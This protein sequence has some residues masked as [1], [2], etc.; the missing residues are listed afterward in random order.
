MPARLLVQ[1]QLHRPLYH[2]GE[3]VKCTV[4]LSPT[5][6]L[7]D[8]KYDDATTPYDTGVLDGRCARA[9]PAAPVEVLSATLVCF[10][11][12]R[13]DAARLQIDDDR[14]GEWEQRLRD[15]LPVAVGLADVL[16]PAERPPGAS[17]V[18]PGTHLFIAP[19]AKLQPQP[20]NVAPGTDVVFATTFRLPPRL[21]PTY[22][23]RSVRVYYGAHLAVVS[24][25]VGGTGP[26][27]VAIARVPIAVAA[28]LPSL[29]L[30]RSPFVDTGLMTDFEVETATLPTAPTPEQCPPLCDGLSVAASGA[31]PSPAADSF[32]LSAALGFEQE[33]PQADGA[34]TESCVRYRG[35]PVL[36]LFLW[37]ALVR[38]GDA[39]RGVLTPTPGSA[40]CC[41][42]AVMRVIVDETVPPAVLRRGTIVP[43]GS[44]GRSDGE[45][46]MHH[47]VVDEREYYV[48]NAVALPLEYHLPATTAQQSLRT[49]VVSLR[50]SASFTF[51]MARRA[52]AHGPA[53]TKHLLPDPVVLPV[54]LTVYVPV[55]FTAPNSCAAPAP[56]VVAVV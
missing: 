1:G 49:D 33:L 10:G 26:S 51:H 17:D 41:V 36:D 3:A 28:P 40:Y 5:A 12:M 21:P 43:A 48:G 50:W 47:D 7:P 6:A 46:V 29:C 18:P 2:P 9:T 27:T 54:P 42:R 22:R 14:N 11:N 4:T 38:H 19:V 30:L 20:L 39:L 52:D 35:E 32:H 53:A 55:R 44:V 31:A 56:P 8:A 37:S 25:P 24:R 13:G 23:G 45:V 34:P 16:A 15:H